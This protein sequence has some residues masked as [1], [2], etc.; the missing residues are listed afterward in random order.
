MKT[1][2]CDCFYQL[3]LYRFRQQFKTKLFHYPARVLQCSGTGKRFSEENR[4]SHS[5]GLNSK[6]K[7]DIVPRWFSDMWVPALLLPPPQKR[8]LAKNMHFWS[9]WPKYWPFWLILC[10]ARPKNNANEVNRW[11][12]DMLVPKLLLPHKIIRMFGPKTAIFPQKYVFFGSYRSHL[13]H[14]CL[15]GWWLWRAGCISQETY[16]LYCHQLQYLEYTFLFSL[17]QLWKKQR[18]WKSF[19]R[20]QKSLLWLLCSGGWVERKVLTL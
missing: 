6:T 11:F 9:F 16:L 19:E 12:S 10:H 2:H 20:F 7:R 17:H 13:V 15:V 4:L 1:L 14:C 5:N 18:N 3:L 8:F